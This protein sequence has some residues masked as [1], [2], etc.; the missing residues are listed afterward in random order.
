MS[1]NTKTYGS[2][3][4]TVTWT[5]QSGVAGLLFTCVVEGSCKGNAIFLPA[6]GYRLDGDL[7]S[8]GAAGCYW[9]SS[10][11]TYN[12]NNSYFLNFTSEYRQMQNF[13]RYWGHS[14]RPVSE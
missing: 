9:T 14:I 10:L 12:R 11:F 7:N 8:A 3:S 2:I 5:T 1:I 13:Q 4:C 6:A